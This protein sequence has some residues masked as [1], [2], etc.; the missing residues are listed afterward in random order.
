MVRLVFGTGRRGGDRCQRQSRA[1]GRLGVATGAGAA[2]LAGGGR[3]LVD[4]RGVGVVPRAFDAPAAWSAS[5]VRVEFEAVFHSARVWVNGTFAGEHLRK[6]YTA[7][8]LDITALVRWG[9][10]NTIVV[11]VDNRFDDRMLPR[12]RSSDWAH[13]GGIYRPVQL[14]VTP[15]SYVERLDITAVPDLAAGSARVEV[16]ALV[17]NRGSEARQR[18]GHADDRG[19]IHRPRG[20]VAAA[21]GDACRCLPVSPGALPIVATIPNGPAVALRSPAPLPGARVAST[22]RTSHEVGIHVRRPLVRDPGRR[23]STSTANACGSWASSGWPAA[24]PSSAWPNR[25]R[26]SI[27]TTRTC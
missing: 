7:F 14:L 10:A 21:R 1:G 3:T 5:V 25:P 19:R 6:G 27:T 22:R 9:A 13:D 17:H 23:A 24:T 26:G 20:G 15:T 12:G 18:H 8:T 16:S 2:H 4:H 11:R